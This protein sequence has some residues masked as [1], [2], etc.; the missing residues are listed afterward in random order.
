MSDY[1][2]EASERSKALIAYFLLVCIGVAIFSDMSF[3]LWWFAIIPVGMIAISV[4]G[5]LVGFLHVLL[6]RK[7]PIES[8]NS[9]SVVIGQLLVGTLGSFYLLKTVHGW[10]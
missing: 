8:L 10:I 9:L 2:R 7:P 1:D 3:G 4:A 5:G 6:F